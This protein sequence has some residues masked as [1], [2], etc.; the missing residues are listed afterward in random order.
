MTSIGW[1]FVPEHQPQLIDR[2]MG[3]ALARLARKRWPRDTAKQVARAWDLDHCTA[4]NVT[5]GKASERTITKAIKAEGWALL[6]PLGEALTGLTFEQHLNTIIEET[7][8]ARQ[9]LEGRRDRVRHLEA[10]ASGLA[11]MGSRMAAE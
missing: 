1:E 4:E 11:A 8:R 3:E 10:R 5:R 7:E 2:T 9:R 6:A